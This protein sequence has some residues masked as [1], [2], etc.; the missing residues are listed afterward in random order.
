MC[1]LH[2]FKN[3]NFEKFIFQNHLPIDNSEFMVIIHV[4]LIIP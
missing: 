4:L 3:N 2:F 1:K